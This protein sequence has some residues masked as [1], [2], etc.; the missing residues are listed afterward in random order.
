MYSIIYNFVTTANQVVTVR[1]YFLQIAE[2]MTPSEK[3]QLE[4]VQTSIKKLSAA[5]LLIDETLFLLDVYQ[6]YH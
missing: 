1:K 3:Q 4:K 5:E 6:R 2:M